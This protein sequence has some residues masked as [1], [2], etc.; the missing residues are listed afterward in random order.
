MARAGLSGW[1]PVTP[2]RTPFGDWEIFY[3]SPETSR[4]DCT[5]LGGTL[6]R[7]TFEI[8]GKGVSPPRPCPA[9]P[10]IRGGR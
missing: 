10:K 6:T 4:K 9:D 1:F 2:C 3:Q 8:K 5:W 7:L